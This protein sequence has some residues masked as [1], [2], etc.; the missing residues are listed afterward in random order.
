MAERTRLGNPDRAKGWPQMMADL[1]MDSVGLAMRDRPRCSLGYEVSEAGTAGP[2]CHEPS[3]LPDLP[4]YAERG[5]KRGCRAQQARVRGLRL[6]QT[7]GTGRPSDSHR[8]RSLC[9]TSARAR[10]IQI[11]G[12]SAKLKQ[13]T[14]LG[15]RSVLDGAA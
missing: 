4:P 7:I 11:R 14:R 8:R 2:D 5:R 1:F 15:G 6:H 10:R 3:R 9:E 12:A 13:R